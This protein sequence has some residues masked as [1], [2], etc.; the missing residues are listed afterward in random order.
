VISNQSPTFPSKV[1]PGN[2]PLTSIKLRLTPSGERQCLPT[3][4][5]YWCTSAMVGTAKPDSVSKNNKAFF[6]TDMMNAENVDG[7]SRMVHA[8][9]IFGGFSTLHCIHHSN[10]HR[11]LLS[12]TTPLSP[13]LTLLGKRPRSAS[14]LPGVWSHCAAYEVWLMLPGCRAKYG[15][16][17]YAQSRPLAVV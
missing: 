9:R 3:S 8:L 5:L 17:V 13:I 7:C 1:G 4:K 12:V 11:L 15:Y 10:F 14:L 2:R 6:G 16:L